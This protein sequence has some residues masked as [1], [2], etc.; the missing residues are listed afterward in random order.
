MATS[1][2][3]LKDQQLIGGIACEPLQVRAVSKIGRGASRG[4]ELIS[5]VD[6]HDDQ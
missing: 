2:R 4:P 6:E 3:R 1:G 5:P